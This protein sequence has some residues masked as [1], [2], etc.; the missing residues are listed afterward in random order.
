M[1]V[2]KQTLVVVCLMSVMSCAVDERGSE[3]PSAS[4]ASAVKDG[5]FTPFQVC[6]VISVQRLPEE[7]QLCGD[8]LCVYPE[9][10]YNCPYDCGGGGYCGDGLCA[11]TESTAS[12]PADCG[13]SCGDGVCNG[14]EGT[15]D[16]PADCGTSC[17]DGVCNGAENADSCAAD[18]SLP[19]DPAFTEAVVQDGGAWQLKRLSG[20]A[21]DEA[22]GA[23]RPFS[24]TYWVIQPGG[25]ATAPLPDAIKQELADQAGDPNAM[26]TLSSTI[27]N[28]I[29]VSL[30]QGY[31]TPSLAAIA[32][33]YDGGP[34]PIAGPLPKGF[35]GDLETMGSCSDRLIN[36]SKSFNVST[37]LNLSTNPGGGFSGTLSA[38]G[39]IQAQA[40]G[41]IE[42]ALKRA[43]VLFWC[44]PYGVRLHY[45]RANGTAYIEYGSQITGTVNYTKSWEWDLTKIPLFSLNFFIGPIPVH[46]GFNLPINYGLDLQATATGQVT[47]TGSQ[48]ANGWFD[49]TCT[50]SGCTGGAS[51]SQTNPV[52]PQL[53]TAGVSGRIQPHFWVQAAVRA[54]LY[55]EWLAYAQIGVRP[56]VR[57]DLWGYYGN[58]CGD[59]NSDGLF[60][61]VDALALDL[62]LQV[63]LTAQARA[64]GAS[65]TQWN[66]L[67]HTPRYHL[68]FWDLIGSEA[69]EPM[70]GGSS[71]AT[72]GA[73]TAYT[74]KMRPCFPWTDNVTYGLSWG[75]ATS[76]TLTG[77]PQTATSAS[78][79]WSTAGS[80]SLSL[81]ARYDAHGRSFNKSTARTVSVG[82]G[83]TWTAWLD[84]DDPSGAGDY[85]TRVDF[86]AA[87]CANPIAI[88][89]Q[90][91]A[92]VDWTQTGEVYSCTAAAGGVC[93]NSSQP[94]GACMDY[95]V[96]F[97]CP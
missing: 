4:A 13:T 97:L 84:R 44:I 47:Y 88:Q 12:C 48:S 96:R 64:F 77:A 93:V 9:D 24:E 38:T 10:M 28:D 52:S 73:S 6:P 23:A 56:Y 51:Y 89:C 17:G 34:L 53:G 27:V 36:K 71:V 5:A 30:R 55:S 46:I 25:V 7:C 83:G 68:G 19:Q 11:P 65:P 74:A 20:T 41:Q 2:V 15:A 21:T 49:Y 43:K 78:H 54:Y 59:A 31:L 95:R 90:T 61:T 35:G 76:S 85:E 8:G 16:C 50:L 40:N 86:G 29:D 82:S 62:D 70:L 14:A 58:N 80:K 32:E 22:T 57:G 87:V 33:S 3:P 45:A 75:D 42:I 94:D 72:V 60:E 1:S 92:G 39:T 66:D 37:P 26:L 91:L 69:M 63:H 81:T 67:W 18:C 79:A